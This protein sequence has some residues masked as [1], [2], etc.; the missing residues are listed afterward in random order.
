MHKKLLVLAVA[1][2]LAYPCAQAQQLDQTDHSIDTVVVSGSR[3]QSWLSE[4][5][6]A[7]GVVNAKT[8]ERDKPK[9][10]GDILN[11]IAGVYWND[12][13]NEQHSMSIRQPIGTNA[14][15]QYLEDGIPIR[16]L[17]VFNHNSLNEMN[18]A[19]ASGV[20]VVKG[21][22]SSLYGSN[23]VGGAVNFLTAGASATPTAKVGVRRDN[24]G[25]YTRY[26][27]SASDTWGPLGLRFSH[28]SSRR[29]RD[30][31][32][33]YSYGDKDSFSLRADYALS[34]TSQLRATIVHTDLDAAMTGSLFENDYRANPGKSL[35][36]FTYRKDKTTR[37][38]LAW[39]GATTANGTSTV[40]VFT[41]KNDHG[42]IPAYSIGSCA[43]MLCKG[44]INNNHVDS[45][46]LDVKHQQEF[47]WLR[48]RLIAGVYVDKSDNPFVSDNLS[49][50]RD[51]ATG[52]YLRYTLANASNPQGVRDYQT[53]ILNTA[54]FAQWEFSPLAGTRVVLGG[55]SDAIRYDYHNNLAPGGSV[56][57]GAPDESRS[58]SHV[59]P[60][61]G[62]TYAIGQAGSAYANV[63]Q[64]FTPPEVSQLYG[65]TGIADLQPS[66]Y[67]N[68]E[69][70]LRWAFLQGRL[71][72]DTAL[73]RL[74]GRDT[75]VSY[76]L[77]PGNSEN[78]NAGRTRS[79]GLELGL[80]YDSGPFDARFA[81]AIARHRY[82]RYQVSA[83]LDYSGRSMPQAP[84]DITSI[85]IGYKP[86][87]GARVALEA[88]HQGRYWM[89]NANTVEYKG[90]ALLNLRA[91]Y[92][93]ARGLE[94]WAQVRNLM[95]KRYADSASS[96][97]SGVGSYAA[98]TQNQY[99]PGAPRSVM[100]GLGYTFNAL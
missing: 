59:S 97:Y 80:N 86:V 46:G 15:Y 83:S 20:E 79:E 24:V 63:S 52:R 36:T 85:E 92:Q 34:P 58:F 81:T 61:L 9:T 41:R 88:V 53:D 12:L 48:S 99:T 94:A 89:N 17:G 40:T 2:T 28:Y 82:L 7:I 91:S 18:M 54:V 32:Q 23:A 72:L 11:R 55:R 100:L 16:P 4:T 67:N 27:T 77:S 8:L 31:W 68:Y 42:Q 37:M 29:S 35:N 26:D 71:K 14:V 13:G 69:L 57:Y 10:M 1:I 98:N 93:L 43:G 25:G 76:T 45:L 66:V 95:D 5:P 47:A 84:R 39:E 65:K 74:D 19:G 3:A 30:N 22:A 73:Y 64:G 75:I 21:A 49:I 33:E 78:R 90:H 96:S 62:A 60:K 87:A 50:V 38:N 44:V 6:Q 70:G 51:A 56:N